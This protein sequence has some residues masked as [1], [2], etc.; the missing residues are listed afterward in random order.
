MSKK[1]S[2]GRKI[3]ITAA[4]IVVAAVIVIGIRE[5]LVEKTGH[6]TP[7]YP[8]QEMETLLLDGLTEEEYN[9]LFLQTGLGKP[10][11]D[12]ILRK[13]ASPLEKLEQHQE[14]FFAENKYNCNK[15]TIITGEE[16]SV[17]EDGN[18]TEKFQIQQIEDGDI[19]L[20]FSTHSIGWRHGHS[21]IV[22]EKEKGKTLEAVVL[23]SDS[24]IQHIGKWERYPTF[25]QLRIKDTALAELGIS[26]KEAEEM[27]LEVSSE[28]LL[29]IPYGLLT[30]IPVKYVEDIKKTQC[31]H[32]VWYAYKAIGI[33]IDADGGWLVTPND[34][35][36]SEYFD[37]VQVYGVDPRDFA[38]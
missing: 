8:M 28:K 27:L 31:A 11:V 7:D 26:R 10:A 23:G 21:G 15:I 30:G 32:L 29:G 13:E 14:D 22:V 6:Y 25:V 24:Q 37:V 19:L 1:I 5:I 2:K 33:D 4:C 38:E 16:K 34:M 3:W 12:S 35:R 17:D 20:A 18:E 9:T 36:A